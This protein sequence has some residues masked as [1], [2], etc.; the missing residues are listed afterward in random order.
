M[1]TDALIPLLSFVAFVIIGLSD[2]IGP[3]LRKTAAP[4]PLQ[5]SEVWTR[6]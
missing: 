3:G 2:L 6:P 1:P 5:L 4:A